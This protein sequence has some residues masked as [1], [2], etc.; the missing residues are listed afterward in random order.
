MG[1]SFNKG[2]QQKSSEKMRRVPQ[3]GGYIN[4][5]GID[6]MWENTSKTS[7]LYNINQ[8]MSMT[9]SP[10]NAWTY[11]QNGFFGTTTITLTIATDYW[12]D[13]IGVGLYGD[14]DYFSISIN[15][16]TPYRLQTGYFSIIQSEHMF[17]DV[18]GYGADITVYHTTSESIYIAPVHP[19]TSVTENGYFVNRKG[20]IRS[21][22]QA[23]RDAPKL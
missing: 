6:Y 23:A 20:S 21:E 18:Y 8:T 9:Q 4:Y 2:A 7:P 17:F 12:V 10:R 16:T 13:F 22:Y 3:A 1:F 5:Q 14:S 15:G 11:T 19:M